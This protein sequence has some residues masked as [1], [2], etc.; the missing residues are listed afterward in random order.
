MP[1]I[2]PAVD[3]QRM[4]AVNSPNASNGIGHRYFHM[5]NL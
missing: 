4:K 3:G 1:T 5:R 2:H